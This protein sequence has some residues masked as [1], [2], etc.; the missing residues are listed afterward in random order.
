MFWTLWSFVVQPFPT[1]SSRL[2]VEPCFSEVVHCRW[3][4]TPAFFFFSL[5][6]VVFA[7]FWVVRTSVFFSIYL[8]A[9]STCCA[10]VGCGVRSVVL[11]AILIYQT[12][13][14][15]TGGVCCVLCC[16]AYEKDYRR[17]ILWLLVPIRLGW[18]ILHTVLR[19]IHIRLTYYPYPNRRVFVG[20][21]CDCVSSACVVRLS[22]THSLM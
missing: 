18:C 13:F 12:Q 14:L 2:A 6:R 9:Y 22:N 21:G 15:Y 16:C 20:C 5:A 19:T 3:S 17:C 11:C 10:Y 7:R 4:D 8:C 1:L